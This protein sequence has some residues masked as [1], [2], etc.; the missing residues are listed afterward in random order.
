MSRSA[1]KDLTLRAKDALLALQYEAVSKAWFGYS[2]LSDG[3][4]GKE[5]DDFL[6]AVRE[7]TP[8][9]PDE[10]VKS[11]EYGVGDIMVAPFLV[12]CRF[13]RSCAPWKLICF[14]SQTRIFEFSRREAYPWNEKSGETILNALN[15]DEFKQFRAYHQKLAKWDA[16]QS[17]VDWGKPVFTFGIEQRLIVGT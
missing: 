11:D 14:G 5:L 1:D 15:A 16:L 10:I 6:N 13:D 9:I 12:S 7:F 8:F 3:G 4:S 2:V 17:T